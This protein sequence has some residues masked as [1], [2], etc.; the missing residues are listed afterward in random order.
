MSAGEK[1]DA[2]FYT[3]DL[4]ISAGVSVNS[5][6]GNVVLLAGDDILLLATASVT[7]SGQITMTAGNGD[8]D[9]VGTL[10]QVGTL[11][12]PVLVMNA[13]GD[14]TIY[15][16]SNATSVSASTSNGHCSAPVRELLRLLPKASKVA[17]PHHRLAVPARTGLRWCKNKSAARPMLHKEAN[18]LR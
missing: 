6:A 17:A 2:P 4:T 8:L 7:A 11:N 18:W 3:D 15:V 10:T 16:I 14:I 12:A 1:S 9:G 13:V 5:S